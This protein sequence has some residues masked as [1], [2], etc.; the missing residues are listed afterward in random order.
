MHNQKEKHK[1]KKKKP[2]THTESK[3]DICFWDLDYVK[4]SPVYPPERQGKKRVER[5]REKD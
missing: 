4:D 5:E 3:G 2:T 1:K